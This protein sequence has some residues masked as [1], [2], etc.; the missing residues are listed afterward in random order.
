M[1]FTVGFR[2]VNDDDIDF[3]LSLRKR[4]MTKHLQDAGI[5][6]TNDEHLVRIKE[7]YYQSHIILV[8]RKPVGV[9]KLGIVTQKDMIFFTY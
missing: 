1:K 4:S 3:L 6:L 2:K 8:D 9:F 5:R 7:F